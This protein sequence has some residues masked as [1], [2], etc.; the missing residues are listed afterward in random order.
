M[1]IDLSCYDTRGAPSSTRDRALRPETSASVLSGARKM[2]LTKPTA[3]TV[4]T[5][6]SQV[7]RTASSPIALSAREYRLREPP[8][9]YAGRHKASLPPGASACWQPRRSGCSLS[10]ITSACGLVRVAREPRPHAAT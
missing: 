5:A 9:L 7:G 6:P 8:C 1:L 10:V 4:T 3:P 2:A